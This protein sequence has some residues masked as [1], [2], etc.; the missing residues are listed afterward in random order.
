MTTA[1]FV[2]RA[3]QIGLSMSDLDSLEYGFVVD[4]LTEAANDDCEYSIV[5]TQEDFDRF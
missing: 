5:A 4:M 3:Y 2:L 1:L